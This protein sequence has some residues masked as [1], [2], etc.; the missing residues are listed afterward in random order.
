MTASASPVG[1]SDVEYDATY[2]HARREGALIFF[3]WFLC[4][5]WAVPVCYF[6][7]Y[8]SN[9]DPA[10]LETLWGIPKWVFWGLVVPWLAAD[11]FTVWLCFF[12]MKDDDLGED[13]E[14]AEMHAADAAAA[15]KGG[16]A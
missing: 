5:I 14:V 6:T 7:G 1:T 4:L 2:I 16:E 15:T 3:V 12:Y 11:V 9:I 13:H 8:D 10:K